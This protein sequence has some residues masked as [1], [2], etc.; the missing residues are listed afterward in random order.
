MTRNSIVGQSVR[1]ERD[2]VVS[3]STQSAVSLP[4]TACRSFKRAAN[5]LVTNIYRY[6]LCILD[7]GPPCMYGQGS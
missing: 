4:F 2:E 3:S 5:V 7:L 1:S 6:L